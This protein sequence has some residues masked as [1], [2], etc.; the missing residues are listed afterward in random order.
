MSQKEKQLHKIN[1]FITAEN[2]GVDLRNLGMAGSCR[3]EPEVAQHIA[4][5]GRRGEWDVATLCMGI[6]VLSWEPAKIEER[7]RYMIH[8]V[9][10]ANPEKHIFCISP[11]YCGS[12]YKGESAAAN[13]RTIIE[14]LV[15][16]YN[17]PY[18]HYVS[19]L[20][21]L[22]NARGLSGDRVHP[23][24]LGVREIAQNLTAV[25]AAVVK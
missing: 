7:V 22:G 12:D 5:M 1:T 10:D 15:A 21:L 2:L 14:R 13:W 18:V 9:A 19:G 25:M 23:S 4:K 17:S 6:N 20:A 8:T 24:P 3:M 16:E 11:L